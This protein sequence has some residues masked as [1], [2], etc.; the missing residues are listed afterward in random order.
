MRAAEL[1]HLHARKVRGEKRAVPPSVFFSRECERERERA[2]GPRA[3]RAAELWIEASLPPSFL[4]SFLP[5]LTPSTPFPLCFPFFSLQAWTT[6]GPGMYEAR[7]GFK[8][9]SFNALLNVGEAPRPVRLFAPGKGLAGWGAS[10]S[11]D[12][13]S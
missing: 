6:P 11:L 4:P 10:V 5:F 12:S 1:Q 8:N 9:A 3:A 13:L 7:S 2:G